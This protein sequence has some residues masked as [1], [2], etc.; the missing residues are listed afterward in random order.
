MING[1]VV[2]ALIPAR[3]GS[4]G[5]PGKNL[6][7][8]AGRSLIEWAVTCAQESRYVDRIILSTDSPDIAQEGERVGAEVPFL[9]PDDLASDTASSASVVTHALR[10]LGLDH[11]LLVLLQPTSPLRTAGDIDAC[12]ELAART[13]ETGSVSVSKIEKSPYWMFKADAEGRLSSFLP[14]SERPIRRQDAPETLI[15]NGAVYVVKIDT[16]LASGTFPI[17]GAPAHIMSADRSIDI[18]TREDLDRAD[19]ILRRGG[20]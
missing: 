16:F 6:A 9:R 18:D 5:F 19:S 7:R 3:G 12:I 13:G 8:L 11:G 15:L 17:D 10:T 1:Q 14:A 2:V 4:K 20:E